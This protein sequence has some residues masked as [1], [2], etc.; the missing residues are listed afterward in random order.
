[1][2]YVNP[3]SK[4]VTKTDPNRLK[5]NTEPGNVTIGEVVQTILTGQDAGVVKF[6]HNRNS[7]KEVTTVESSAQPLFANIKVYPL[8]G[9]YVMLINLG[10]IYYIPLN[11]WNNPV[12]NIGAP[13]LS[14]TLGR[15][16]QDVSKILGFNKT[17]SSTN[18]VH[19]ITGAQE[20]DVV[21]EGRFGQSI[22]FGSTVKLNDESKNS[23]STSDLS[24][25]GDP[26]IIIRNGIQNPLENITEDYSSIYLCSTQKIRIDN[27]NNGFDG[28][29]APWSTINV[30]SAAVDIEED[31]YKLSPDE[32]QALTQARD[33]AQQ[34]VSAAVARGDSEGAKAAQE[35][36]NYTNRQ[37]QTG[38]A[39]AVPYTDVP[40]PQI[41]PNV[42]ELCKKIIAYAQKD[43]GVVEEPANSNRGP[44]VD[45]ML[46]GAGSSPGNF[47]C[48]AA[49]S[50][51]FKAA[52]ADMPS[53]GLAS[54][55][56]WMRWAQQRGLFSKTP[57]PGAAILYGTLADAHHVGI[58]ESVNLTTYPE[59][60]SVVTIEGNT[61][62]GKADRNGG[63]VYRKKPN[64]NAANFAVVG[65]VL[66]AAGGKLAACAQTRK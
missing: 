61:S 35:R 2:A 58:V 37:I 62:S 20:G 63:G 53:G 1:M 22:K 3:L 45:Q 32:L 5:F 46:R 48:A 39:S 12:N 14:S 10:K 8:A 59:R 33:Q 42:T 66:P 60:G 26:I 15:Q 52:G 19:I 21:F 13:V 31:S 51:W 18:K 38:E 9:E 25:N 16:L 43:V 55:D 56:T 4:G 6:R 11:F 23:W 17:F 36:V 28:I 40:P 47:W 24:N 27:G 64:L 54:C 44:R 30:S 50:A 57:V 7:N 41:D 65:Y 29:T 49:V 34:E